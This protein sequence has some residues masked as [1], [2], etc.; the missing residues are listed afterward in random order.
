MNYQKIYENLISAR[1]ES[2]FTNGEYTELHH[3]IPKCLGG[4]NTSRNLV[5]LTAREHFLAHRLLSKIY[6]G[7]KELMYAV[8]MMIHTRNIKVSSRVYEKAKIAVSESS[9]DF[10][11]KLWKR[12]GFLEKMSEMKT[13]NN[14]KLWSDKQFRTKMEISLKAFWNE[15]NKR[16]ASTRMVIFWSHC[17]EDER[18][19]RIRGMRCNQVLAIEGR[20]QFYKS[21]PWPWQR[22]GAGKTRKVW[23]LAA[24][25]WI[26]REEARLESKTVGYSKFS[27]EYLGGKFKKVTQRMQ[28]MFA[29]GWNP[30]ECEDYIKE[31]RGLM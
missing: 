28:T 6:P 30:L 14:N 21:N 19:S 12:E 26:L 16:E 3:I 25:F 13:L 31:F 22:N 5:R 27:D 29:E 4:N 11:Q 23:A 9:R 17:S 1:R 15:K 7:S 20:N 10:I 18:N 8:W 24:T 2:K